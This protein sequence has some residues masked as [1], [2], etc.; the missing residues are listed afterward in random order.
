MS[1]NGLLNHTF[2]REVRQRHRHTH[3]PGVPA[4]EK[5]VIVEI[6]AER[7][8]STAADDLFGKDHEKTPKLGSRRRLSTP[9]TGPARTGRGL[10]A[11][12]ARPQPARRHRVAPQDDDVK[13][14]DQKLSGSLHGAPSIP[15]GTVHPVNTT[16]AHPAALLPVTWGWMKM[17]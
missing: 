8:R 14:T 6:G 12:H 16:Q 15:V 5:V 13:T 17:I 2:G 10:L 7:S 9:A 3:T 11:S 4:L 1:G